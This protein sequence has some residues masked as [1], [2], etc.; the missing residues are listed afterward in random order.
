M[1]KMYKKYFSLIEVMTVTVIFTIMIGI[2]MQ[3][4]N[5]ANKTWQ[6]SERQLEVD[7]QAQLVFATF[8]MLLARN[9]INTTVNNGSSSA[10]ANGF[11]LRPVMDGSTA[12]YAPIGGTGSI[13]YSDRASYCVFP[14]AVDALELAPSRGSNVYVVGIIR[15][16]RDQLVVRAVSDAYLAGSSGN[17]VSESASLTGVTENLYDLLDLTRGDL[18]GK[19]TGSTGFASEEDPF[20][21]D[22]MG[23][24]N[25]LASNV[26]MFR[27]D[28]MVKL[29]I[30]T[31]NRNDYNNA[32]GIGVLPFNPEGWSLPG[33]NRETNELA[34]LRVEFKML[35]AADY[36]RWMELWPRRFE[37]ND[38]EPAEA[39]KFRELHERTYVRVLPVT[40][41]RIGI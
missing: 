41:R 11:A 9:Q 20:S 33:P 29:D 5:N 3:I 24:T 37:D 27:V 23:A 8:D 22:L 28:P 17:L 10:K 19:I 12:V 13:Y 16:F 36:Q 39:K 2:A 32:L 4:F 7:I 6:A 1:K 31:A 15:N 18:F 25:L 14:T 30:T 35:N 21:N 26:T 34:A 38:S 40:Q